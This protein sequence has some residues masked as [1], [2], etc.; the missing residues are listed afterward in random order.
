MEK[1]IQH[2]ILALLLNCYLLVGV[3]GH[4]QVL[5]EFFGRWGAPHSLAQSKPSRPA[6]SKVYWT[7]HKHIPAASRIVV[8]SPATVAAPNFFHEQAFL[9][10]VRL[11]DS[12]LTPHAL[13]H[14]HNSRAPPVS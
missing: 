12:R 8:P 9:C 2:S 6:T 13:P 4:L 1:R 11:E 3:L 5:Y 7:Q 10:L 14:A